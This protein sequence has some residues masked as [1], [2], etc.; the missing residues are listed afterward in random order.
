VIPETT[1]KFLNPMVTHPRFELGVSKFKGKINL[2]QRVNLL[3]ISIGNLIDKKDLMVATRIT[4]RH[5]HSRSTTGSSHTPSHDNASKQKL[6]VST[7]NL[8]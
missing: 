3:K 4:N 7:L 8:P 2:P 1:S 6:L 5:I